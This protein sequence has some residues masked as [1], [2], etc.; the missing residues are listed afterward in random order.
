MVR[1]RLT[2]LLDELNRELAKSP[3]LDAETTQQIEEAAAALD[4][5][6]EQQEAA[7]EP[8][9]VDAI[10]KKL[11]KLEMKHPRISAITGE[12]MDLISKLGV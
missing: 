7:E 1:K 4:T 2:Q 5:Y 9:M 8:G 11:L 6:L 12:A 10:H 3:D